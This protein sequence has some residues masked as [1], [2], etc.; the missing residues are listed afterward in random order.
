MTGC[1]EI[2]GQTLEQHNLV[3]KLDTEQANGVSQHWQDDWV[4][5]A[6]REN[7][8]KKEREQPFRID[9]CPVHTD[10]PPPINTEPAKPRRMYIRKLS[11]TVHESGKRMKECHVQYLMRN[12][13]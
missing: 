8:E 3:Q 12:Q 4:Q 2:L 5:K 13:A 9:V 1:H 6:S 7:P 11:S 10:F